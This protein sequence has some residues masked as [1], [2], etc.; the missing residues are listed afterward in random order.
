ML[1]CNRL[2]QLGITSLNCIENVGVLF[3]RDRRGTAIYEIA[4][5]SCVYRFT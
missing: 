2:G 5:D 1:E 3:D 4:P